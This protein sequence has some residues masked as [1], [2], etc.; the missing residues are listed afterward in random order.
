MSNFGDVRSAIQEH[1]WN[2]LL[3][4]IDPSDAESLFYALDSAGPAVKT[5]IFESI[6]NTT[7]GG[8]T[9]DDFAELL[10]ANHHMMIHIA[11]PLYTAEYHSINFN[12]VSKYVGLFDELIVMRAEGLDVEAFSY[13][14]AISN[15]W[16]ALRH[17]D[18]NRTHLAG[19]A[20]MEN[21]A[22][23]LRVFEP[24]GSGMVYCI[25]VDANR[26]PTRHSFKFEPVVLKYEG[27]PASLSSY[28]SDSPSVPDAF[29]RAMNKMGIPF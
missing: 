26:T 24:D 28:F 2:R 18:A 25:S 6:A 23:W 29:I 14:V 16:A 15:V 27:S 7:R 17:F 5:L 1:D 3:E 10:P 11:T 19:H 20:L 13:A 9:L 12:M 8:L 22:E 4:V 21:Y